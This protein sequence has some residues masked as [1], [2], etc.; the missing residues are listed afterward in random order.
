MFKF[1][2]PLVNCLPPPPKHLHLVLPSLNTAQLL[3]A[4][5][6]VWK[7]RISYFMRVDLLNIIIVIII[8]EN[9][10]GGQTNGPISGRGDNFPPTAGTA[11][12]R[13]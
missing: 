9:F 5:K 4:I 8:L 12:I 13:V 10:N 6:R 2:V 1:S 3:V 11:A 7:S